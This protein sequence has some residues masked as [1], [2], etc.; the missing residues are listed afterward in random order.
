[1]NNVSV[2]NSTSS[3]FRNKGREGCN[4]AFAHFKD[5]IKPDLV[6]IYITYNPQ[7]K[8]MQSLQTSEHC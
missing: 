8:L 3:A 1:M 2:I 4:G 7:I 5:Q 6:H